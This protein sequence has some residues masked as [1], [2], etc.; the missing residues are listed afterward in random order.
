MKYNKEVWKC[1]PGYS[2]YIASNLGNI[3]KLPSFA[4]NGTSKVSGKTDGRYGFILSPRPTPPSG[5]LQLSITNDK[6]ERKMEYVHRLVALAFIKKRPGREI[7]L[8]KDDNPSNNNVNNLMWG[9]HY[10]NSQM[11]TFR[12]SSTTRGKMEENIEKVVMLYYTNKPL[13][14]GKTKDLVKSISDDLGI[15]IAYV[16]SLMYCPRAKELL[17]KIRITNPTF[18]I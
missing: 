13:Y 12:K 5:H 14:A 10:M 11:I 9:T 7:V 8:H 18:G 17:K 15:T 3:M 4:T 2:G 1:I 6:G 16:Y